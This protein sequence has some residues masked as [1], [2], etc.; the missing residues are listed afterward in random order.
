MRGSVDVARVFRDFGESYREAYG[1]R[2]TRRHHRAMRAIELCRTAALGGHVDEC[3]QCGALRI[4]Y[5]SCR[6]RHCPKCQYLTREVWLEARKGDL[7][8][9]PYVHLV[10]T[11]PQELRPLA[12]RNQKTVYTI[13]FKAASET[14]MELSRDPRHLGA[15]IGC[16]AILHTWSQSLIDHPH[17]HCLVTG[18]GL[19]PDGTRWI[20]AKEDYFMPVKV[21]SRLFRGKFLDYLRKAYNGE[22]LTFPGEIASLGVQ[23]TFRRYL[24]GLYDREWVVYCKEPFRSARH[25]LE[26]LGRYTHRVAI[27]NDRIVRVSAHEVTFRVRDPAKVGKTKLMTLDAFEFIRRFLLH[28]LPDQ[29]MK[30]RYYGLLSNRNRKQKLARC[31]KLLGVSDSA[32]ARDAGKEGWEAMLLRITG[33]DLRICPH[34]GKSTMRRRELLLPRVGRWPP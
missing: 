28:I 17:V 6:N 2:M 22:E 19:V 12:L 21:L 27:S 23:E 1:S 33:I 26:Y 20:P 7:L 11:I 5:N 4:S 25:A 18:G 3:D 30:I 32:V 13:L 16:I 15:Q 29:F 9:V 34:C 14:V 8:P 31:R 10:F 24:T